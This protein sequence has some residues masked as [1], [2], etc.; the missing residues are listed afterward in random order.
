[1]MNELANLDVISTVENM[2]INK[3]DDECDEE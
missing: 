1:M 3:K 2:K